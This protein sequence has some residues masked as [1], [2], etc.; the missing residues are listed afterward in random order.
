MALKTA[1][2]TLEIKTS[3][4]DLS[5]VD[6][7]YV[8]IKHTDFQTVKSNSDIEVDNELISVSLSQ[9]EAAQLADGGGANVSIMAVGAD[10]A[11]TTVKVAWVRRGSRTDS[12]SGDGESMSEEQVQGMIDSS[13]TEVTSGA[14]IAQDSESNWGY[15]PPGQ[16]E[17]IPFSSGGGGGMTDEQYNILVTK[18]DSIKAVVDGHTTKLDAIKTVVD[19]HTT[20]LEEISQSVAGG[21]PGTVVSK[22]WVIVQQSSGVS[23]NGSRYTI[24]YPTSTSGGGENFLLAINVDEE[25]DVFVTTSYS[26]GRYYKLT[27]RFNDEVVVDG[28]DGNNSSNLS[29][30]FTTRTFHLKKGA[31]SIYVSVVK[32]GS[33][34]SYFHLDVASVVE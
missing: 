31:N 19:G 3:G 8:T 28:L 26:S 27:M 20:K 6:T 22:D 13:I 14:K 11:V 29:Q 12:G 10:S 24:S 4:T 5:L 17:V 9:E 21:P 34:S 7:L 33:G 16:S 30:M 18:L 23:Q 25:R 15:I 1:I 32:S 2:P